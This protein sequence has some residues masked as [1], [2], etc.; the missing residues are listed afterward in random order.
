MQNG[1][2]S[3]D[4]ASHRLVMESRCDLVD[5]VRN[6]AER[7]FAQD[8]LKGHNQISVTGGWKCEIL[9]PSYHVIL[10]F[11]AVPPKST[12]TLKSTLQNS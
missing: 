11:K 2:R 9:T 5:G 7:A 10:A 1:R 3:L 4:Q 12:F 8:F 6:N